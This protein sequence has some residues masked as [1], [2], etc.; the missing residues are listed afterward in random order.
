RGVPQPA[1]DDL[2]ALAGAGPQG[3]AE[4]AAV[5]GDDAGG[6]GEDLRRRAVVLLQ[7]DDQRAGEIAL[8]FEDVADLG[9][10]PAV[11][12]L[13]VVADA[14]QVAVLLGQQPQPQIL[15]D[16]GV[17]V[18]VDQQVAEAALVAGG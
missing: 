15:R 11:D 1:H 2:V 6:G 14:A 8:E 9:A 10:A 17:L 16:V 3:L 12:R 18:L 13:I 4:A 7:P 5:V